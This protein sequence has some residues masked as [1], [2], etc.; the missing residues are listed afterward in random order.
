M[1]TQQ[2][3]IFSDLVKP[4]KYITYIIPF[5]AVYPFEMLLVGPLSK[6]TKQTN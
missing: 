5:H 6:K 1:R 4:K 2:S 3:F